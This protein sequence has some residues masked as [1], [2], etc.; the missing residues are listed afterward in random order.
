MGEKEN[1]VI[2]DHPAT[3]T[4]FT[5]CPIL[6]RSRGVVNSIGPDT[7]Q[8]SEI[9]VSISHS[10]QLRQG[11]ECRN[12]RID[13]HIAD[14]SNMVTW[15]GFRNVVMGWKALGKAQVSDLP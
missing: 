5:R 2:Q 7:S 9:C 4:T 13:Y 6:S 3:P 14:S 1:K 15:S 8:T 12:S 11:P 10:R